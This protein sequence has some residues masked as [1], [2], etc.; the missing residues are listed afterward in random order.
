[1][2]D[3]GY[4]LTSAAN[5][6]PCGPLLHW[7]RADRHA[8]GRLLY[9]GRW[10]DSQAIMLCETA[11]CWVARAKLAAYSNAGLLELGK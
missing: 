9:R 6:R 10:F 3:S 1:M 5:R 7:W 4:R 2:I 8:L 11:Q